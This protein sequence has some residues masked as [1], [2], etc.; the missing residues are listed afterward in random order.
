MKALLGSRGKKYRKEEKLFVADGL[1][2]VREALTPKIASAPKIE[3]LYVTASGL[4]KPLMPVGLIPLFSRLAALIFI[5]RRL[6][7]QP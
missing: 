7:A 6:F 5:V 1:Q 2:S 4:E 3:R